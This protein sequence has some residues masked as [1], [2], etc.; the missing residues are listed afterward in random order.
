MY[1]SVD[2]LTFDLAPE[3]TFTPSTV[4]ENC[5]RSIEPFEKQLPVGVPPIQV[6]S[7]LI[8]DKSILVVASLVT[9]FLPCVIVK[10]VLDL[11]TLS[12]ISSFL[13][14]YCHLFYILKYKLLNQMIILN[15]LYP[16]L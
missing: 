3:N 11:V 14:N 1:V 6:P 16:H 9:E 2:S 8:S 12:S 5:L 13:L 10:Y 7:K 15:Q 4:I